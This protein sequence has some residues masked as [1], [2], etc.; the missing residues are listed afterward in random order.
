M[1]KL[2]SLRVYLIVYAMVNVIK[3][4]YGCLLA[5]YFLVLG[6]AKLRSIV[7]LVLNNILVMLDLLLYL[8]FFA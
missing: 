4:L 8:F 6:F 2:L 1:I 3:T 5:A 7:H